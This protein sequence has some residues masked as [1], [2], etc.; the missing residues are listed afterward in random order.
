MT[1]FA[2]IY[3]YS[4]DKA[5]ARAK[6]L[7]EHRSW[8]ATVDKNGNLHEAG[9]L[10]ESQGALL[11][12]EFDSLHEAVSTLDEDPFYT[13]GCIE[14]RTITQWKVGWGVVAEASN[15]HQRSGTG[16]EEAEND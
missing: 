12:F 13:A 16:T 9:I 4:Q 5:D 6:L 7:A 1:V 3:A 15:R 2:A 11:A 10:V 14:H 8:L